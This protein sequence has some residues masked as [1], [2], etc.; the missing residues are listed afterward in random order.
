MEEEEEC[1]L[2]ATRSGCSMV[3]EEQVIEISQKL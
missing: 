3:K 1:L 2:V